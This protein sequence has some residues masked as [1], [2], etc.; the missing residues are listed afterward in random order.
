MLERAASNWPCT[1]GSVIG[2]QLK[3]SDPG[4]PWKVW[5]VDLHYF[6]V[7]NGEYYSGEYSLPPD[8]EDEA[9][10]QANRWKERNI[11]VRY[12]PENAEESLILMCDQTDAS[13]S[14]LQHHF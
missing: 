11:V 1:F 12:S 8:S 6:Y 2:A 10:E 7:V 14:A 9:N 4:E 5:S 3:R 13:M